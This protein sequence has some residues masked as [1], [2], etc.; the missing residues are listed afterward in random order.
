MKSSGSFEKVV[1]A[2]QATNDYMPAW[3]KFVNTEFFVA[4]LPQDS[5]SQ[6]K[7][8][9]FAIHNS[10]KNEPTVMVSEELEYLKSSATD[11][12]IK[13]RGAILISTLNHQVSILVALSDGAFGIPVNLVAWL[14]ASIQPAS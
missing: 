11:K 4:V 13:M 3:E 14:R 1:R 8:F 5:G 9:R 6:T 10:P 7:D 2:C 12:A